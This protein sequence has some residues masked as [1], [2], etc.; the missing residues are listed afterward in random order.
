MAAA[1]PSTTT[2]YSIFETLCSIN[3]YWCATVACIVALHSSRTPSLSISFFPSRFLF[4][5]THRT[6]LLR[7]R[8]RHFHYVK[9]IKLFDSCLHRLLACVCVYGFIK[10]GSHSILST[11]RL[12]HVHDVCAAKIVESNGLCTLHI[13]TKSQSVSQ[14]LSKSLTHSVIRIHIFF[15]YNSHV[16]NLTH[17]HISKIFYLYWHK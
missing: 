10:N 12:W 17:K 7:H 9:C 6:R 8:H 2:L 13:N 16:P 1:S 14:P 4:L 15:F 3:V 5:L 11:C